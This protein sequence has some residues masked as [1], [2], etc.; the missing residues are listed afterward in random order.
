MKTATEC[1]VTI[2]S[3][4]H[5]GEHGVILGTRDGKI[6]VWLMDCT[7]NETKILIERNDI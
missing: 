6:L 4:P 7:H 5:Y 3:F 1:Y 2:K